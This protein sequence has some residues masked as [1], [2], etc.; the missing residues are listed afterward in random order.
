MSIEHLMQLRYKVIADW[1][2]N[3]WKIGTII[4][5]GNPLY[6]DKYPHLYKKLQ[7][8]EERKVEDMPEY[9]KYIS[10]GKVYKAIKYLERNSLVLIKDDYWKIE[11]K[12][13]L[14][15]PFW[16]PATEE[17]YQSYI[18]KTK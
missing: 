14:G 18:I 10:N 16:M 6:Y 7:W 12:N 2:N 1:P 11:I 5:D 4:S 13:Q 8:W 3:G 17:D 9:I 15:E